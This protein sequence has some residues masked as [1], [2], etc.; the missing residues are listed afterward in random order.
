MSNKSLKIRC[1][2]KY[3]NTMEIAILSAC[4]IL[5]GIFGVRI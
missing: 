4:F 2:D 1:N 5:G 3:N